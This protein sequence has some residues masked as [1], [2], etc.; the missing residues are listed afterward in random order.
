VTWRV[1]PPVAAQLGP[2]SLG[3][4]TMRLATNGDSPRAQLETVLARELA[5]TSVFL[6]QGGTAA[7]A[8]ALDALLDDRRIV[9][10]PAYGCADLVSAALAARA[11][12]VCYDLDPA[13]LGPDLD[14]ARKA[15]QA[16]ASVIVGTHLYGIP[17]DVP[18]LRE[19][20]DVA[21][22]VVVED[23]AQGLGAALGG[24]P[25]G[26]L[27][28]VGV[29]S[30]GRGKGVSGGA[31][32]ALLLRHGIESRL[33]THPSL[34]PASRGL[35]PVGASWV[36]WALGRPALYRIPTALPFLKLGEMVFHE[37]ESPRAMP[38]SCA[39][40]ALSSWKAMRRDVAVRQDHA[41]ALSACLRSPSKQ[42]ISIARS[43]SPSWL[44]WPVLDR[45]GGAWPTELGVQQ[46]YPLS[47]P[48]QPWARAAL[49]GNTGAMP[50]AEQLSR[51]L[52]T[53]PTHHLVRAS[54][55]AA[56][57]TWL[58]SDA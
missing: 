50:G 44:R 25:C 15:L 42:A 13:T 10:L 53:L 41:T 45:T 29:L 46:G 12:I 32:G 49:A 21:G 48:R 35:G 47:I 31:G 4:A 3:L 18:S 55:I 33:R 51:Q 17:F 5:A 43:A 34:Q 52:R 26:S 24:R 14:S 20:A 22:A 7:L 40:L 1:L 37:A 8:L 56:L 38:A 36:Q 23:S 9:A 39:T 16:G 6:T 11:T 58:R 28:D 27:A 2:V 57:A 19:V 30:F 54:D